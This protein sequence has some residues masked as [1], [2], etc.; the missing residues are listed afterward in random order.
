M[1]LLRE[2]AQQARFAAMAWL[3]QESNATARIWAAR[4]ACRGV[5]AAARFSAPLYAL[6]TLRLALP[7]AAEEAA[8]EARRIF[9]R[10]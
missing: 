5:L 3:N 7:E 8:E 9:P 6:L 4:R 2:Q 1:R 10:W